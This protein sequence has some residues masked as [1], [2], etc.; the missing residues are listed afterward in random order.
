MQTKNGYT[1]SSITRRRHRTAKT[2]MA[3]VHAA[4][5]RPVIRSVTGNAKSVAF[6]QAD[7][8]L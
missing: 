8:D 5:V 3:R 1:P 4:S 6:D 2:R 7:G